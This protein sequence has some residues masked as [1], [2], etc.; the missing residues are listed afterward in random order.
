MFCV[1]LAFRMGHHL[2]FNFYIW[3]VLMPEVNITLRFQFLKL[4]TKSL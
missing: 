1:K 3:S 2:V 4:I